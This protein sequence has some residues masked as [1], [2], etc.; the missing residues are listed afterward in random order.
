MAERRVR[1]EV[2]ESKLDSIFSE[3]DQ[4]HLPGAVVGVAIGGRPVYRRGFG[5]A[6]I[7]LPV[8]L[9]PSMRLRIAST[10][11]HLTCFAYL[12]LCEEGLAGIDD[13]IGKHLP[14]L[15]PVGHS[16]TVKQLMGNIGGLRDVY[17]ICD[18]FNGGLGMSLSSAELLALYRDIKDVNAP[19]GTAWL[20]NNG[21]WLLLTATIERITGKPLEQVM[22]ERVFGPIGMHDT[23]VRRSDSDFL[24]N[25]A[26]QH[27]LHPTSGFERRYWGK[28]NLAG[29]AAIVSTVDD[30][31]R[32]LAH[33][34]K[35][36]IGSAATWAALRTPLRLANGTSTGYGLGLMLGRYRGI[37]T[38]YHAGNALGGNAQMLK[39][40]AAG[41]DAVVLSNRQDV[42][43]IELVNRILDTVLPDAAPVK[44]RDSRLT[45]TGVFRSPTSDRVIQLLG[46]DGQ[47]MVSIGGINVPFDLD[48]GNTLH[49]NPLFSYLKQTV[50]LIGDPLQPSGIQLSDFGNIDEFT[51]QPGTETDQSQKIAGRFRSEAIGVEATIAAA[52]D[53]PRLETVGPLGSAA[54]RL[55][56]LAD[57]IW[58]TQ[59]ARLE[60]LGGI[61]AFD[62]QAHGF[63]FSNYQTRPLRFKRCS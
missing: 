4:C 14:E 25:S 29:A 51:R 44:P 19:P 32:W 41:L 61:L 56:C 31:L 15:H 35:P 17:E 2:E 26:S 11:K 7:E 18:Q 60:F 12:L 50:T 13:P 45:S 8:V 22:R 3:I 30:L 42:S 53:G 34:D 47:Q 5:L 63:S 9:T 62:E 48:Q 16:V 38:L 33:M 28:D 57:G 58:R 6:S 43:S 52:E 55:D 1:V 36:V 37:D 23:L 24:P 39:V 40:P 46:K 10:S 20:Y 54:Y 59:P 49:P 27:A 21:G